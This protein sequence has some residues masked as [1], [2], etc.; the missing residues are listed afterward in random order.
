M[1]EQK[2]QPHV[3]KA[4]PY[5]DRYARG[6][7]C[8]GLASDYTDEPQT[9]GYFGGK[10]V[11]YRGS[12]DKVHIL[13]ANC[14]HMGADLSG[15]CVEGNAIRCPF[16]F[17]RWGPDGVCDDIPY[18]K[19]IPP[20]AVIKQWH[21]MEENK[22][23][24]VWNDEEGRPPIEQQRIPRI[25]D[26][27]S[28]QWSGWHMSKMTVYTHPRELMDNMADVAHFAYVHSRGNG[29]AT[30]FS[31]E[32]EGHRYTQ[33]MRS[34]RGTIDLGSFSRAT[35]Q[36]PSVMET[37]M[38]VYPHSD[39]TLHSNEQRLLVMHTPI[40][41]HSF[42]LRFGVLVKKNPEMSEGISRMWIESQVQMSQGAFGQDVEIWNNKVQVD[43]PILC[44]GDGPVGMLRKWFHN[45]YV[46]VDQLPDNYHEKQVTV[47]DLS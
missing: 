14:P 8:L 33:F 24:F 15:G 43:N 42:D 31:N 34:D 27:F 45:F 30:E 35:Y 12:D 10:Q 4:E 16:H 25:D 41:Q 32:A 23:L 22:L 18:A 37:H 9:L 5:P 17:W 36:G 40:D 6:W 2:M 3:I 44:D 47:V 1:D 46:D 28:D 29:G 26:V 7:H 13:D 38:Y 11:A 21:T 39:P 20:K 19:R